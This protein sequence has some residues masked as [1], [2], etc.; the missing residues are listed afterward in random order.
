M[1]HRYGLLYSVDLHPDNASRYATVKEAKRGF[2]ATAQ[3]F[4]FIGV[5]PPEAF[6]YPL[7]EGNDGELGLSDYPIALLSIG[8]RGGLK[9]ET[10]V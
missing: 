1:K 6:L 10:G 3:D 5:S 8:P 9:Y 4:D 7:V 2:M